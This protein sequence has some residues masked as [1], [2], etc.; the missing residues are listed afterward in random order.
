MEL[1]QQILSDIVIFTK[2]A[3]YIPEINRRE[4]WEEICQRNAA[5][6]IQK[7][8]QLREEIKRV[9]KDFVIPKKVLPSMRS[10][11]FAGAPIEISNTRMF[12]CSYNPIDHPF[13]FAEVMFLLLSGCFKAGTMVKIK[14][15]DK[16]IEEVTTDDEVLT[17]NENTQQF[18]WVYPS[19]SGETLTS[20]KQKVKITTDDGTEI[21]A[22]A[23][24]KFL[25]KNRGW[26]ECQNL[27]PDDEI[28]SFD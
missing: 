23:D 12:N 3:R 20:D 7:Y 4:T 16:P 13:A 17:Y 10:M 2:Y 19:W 14:S 6:H 27:T 22:T 11:Q 21:F 5:M 1:S 15:G 25:T 26:V 9:Y 28:I 8:P 24:H 18:E